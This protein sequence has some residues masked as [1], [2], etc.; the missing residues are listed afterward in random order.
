MPNRPAPIFAK[1]KTAAALLDMKPADFRPLV[2]C[3]VLPQPVDFN[4]HER[5][6]VKDLEAIADGSA[7]DPEFEV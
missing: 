4:G 2:E 7:I 1:E 5:W 6:R 3:G